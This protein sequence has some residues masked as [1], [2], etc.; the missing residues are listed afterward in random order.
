MEKWCILPDNLIQKLNKEDVVVASL[1]RFC[2]C[3]AD[4]LF[5]VLK[6]RNKEN[7]YKWYGYNQYTKN[8]GKKIRTISVPQQGLKKIQEA[9]KDRLDQIPVS[10]ASTA[11]KIGDSAEKNIEIHKHNLYLLSMDIKNAYPSI[12]THRVY[13]NLQWALPLKY[14]C[15]Q[16]ITDEDKNLFIKTITHLCVHDNQLPQWASTSGQIQNIV[17]SSLDIQIEKKIPELVWSHMVYSRYAD[18]MAISFP[19]FSTLDVLKEKMERYIQNFQELGWISTETLLDEFSKDTF[20]VTDNFEQKYLQKKIEDIKEI[21]NKPLTSAYDGVCIDEEK[22]YKQVGILDAYKKNIKYSTWR[23]SDIHDEILKV[24]WWEWRKINNIKTNMRTP[25]SDREREINGITIDENGNKWLN[26]RKRAQYMKIFNHL[27][28]HSQDDLKRFTFYR[29]KFNT[30][31]NFDICSSTTTQIIDGI[32]HRI[33]RIYG[34]GRIPKPLHEAYQKAKYK[35][36]SHE[37]YLT[38]LPKKSDANNEELLF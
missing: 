33:A 14:R 29:D 16:L 4:E 20:I 9:I 12:T 32:Y 15:P 26:K 10:L 28:K 24:I 8:N 38:Y 2:K 21:I 27:I 1:T 5:A 19:H 30:L 3:S 7:I 34:T 37:T 18:D 31:E 25:Q 36:S 13:K 17:F 35:R 22:I 23:I 6:N 11:W